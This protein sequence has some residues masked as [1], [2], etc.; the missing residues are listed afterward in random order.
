MSKRRAELPSKI[1]ALALMAI[2]IHIALPASAQT[3]RGG[4]HGTVQD[5][6]NALLPNAEVKATNVETGQVYATLST[7]AGEFTFS[8]L[9]LGSYSVSVRQ[10]GFEP[11]TVSHISVLAGSIYNLPLKVAL[12]TVSSEVNVAASEV[13]L[14]STTSSQSSV[15][16][17]SETENIPLNG[18]DFTQLLTVTPGYSGYGVGFVSAING[19]QASQTNWQIEGVDNNDIWINTSA[20]NQGGVFGI[21]GVLLPLDSV[22]EFSVVTQGTAETGRSPGGTVNLAL[23]SGTND[24]H[25][26][27]YYY[28]RN[29]ALAA[30]PVF[31]DP[32]TGTVVKNKLRDQQ[33]GFTTGGPILKDKTFFFVSYERQAFDIGLPNHVTEPSQAYQT[34]ALAVLNNSG[35][36]YG[37]YAPVPVNPVSVKLLDTLWPASA[38][39]GKAET[40]NYFNPGTE[41][42][43]SNNGV[44]K[45]DHALNENNHLS[46][47]AF[48]A[49]GH[50]TAPTSSYL[51][52]Y[53]ETSPMHVQ[54]WA[55]VYNSTLSPR[56]A[57][58]LLA[59][60]NYFN[61]A[62]SDEN[63]SYNPVALGLNTGVT[64]PQLSGAPNIT[65]GQFDPIGITPYS[66]RHDTTWHLTDAASYS[67][68]KHQLRFG[69]E[70]RRSNV[71]EFYHSG[72][73][74]DFSFTGSQGPWGSST[75]IA[76]PN[77]TA[78]ADFLAGYVSQASIV[79][80]DPA[81]TV[82]TNGFSLFA[83][84]N[85]QVTHQ[86]N[87]NLGLRYDYN[88]PIHDGKSD[89]STFIPGSGGLV[90]VGSGINT[91]YPSNWKNF[92]PHL[93]FAYQPSS[94]A[95]VVLRGGFGL[96]Y[97][98]VAVSSFLGN[99]YIYNGGPAGA[100]DNPAGSKPV[101]TLALYGYTLPTDGSLIGWQTNPIYNLF[102][103][104]QNLRTPY[105]Y[106]FNLNVQK[107][108]G[109]A[110]VAQVGYVG[111][112][113]RHLL[114]LN[115]LNQAAL[116]SEIDPNAYDQNGANT[117]RPY[118]NKFP[119]YGVI[120]QLN[121]SGNSSYNSLQASLRVSGWHGVVSQFSYTWAHTLDYGSFLALPQ[122]SR[123]PAG[124]YGNS[125]FD[126]RQNLT[127]YLLYSLPSSS[128][129][130]R[131]VSD[132]WKLSSLLSFRTGLPFTVSAFSIY[133]DA[134]LTGDFADRPNLTGNP[135]AGVSH[136]VQSH[137]S[138]Q[139][140]NPDAFTI[141]LGQFGTMRRNQLSGPGFSDVD[142]SIL[143]DTPINERVTTQFR[144]EAF[145]LFNRINLGGPTF[146][147][148]NGVIAN[149]GSSNIGIPITYTNGSQFGLPGI[150]PGEPFN[151]Q[152]A[153]KVRF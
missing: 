87:V 44:A 134:S 20:A 64:D 130:L 51:T 60:F 9:P 144:I 31:A 151:L 54:N 22:D 40:G 94:N 96:T 147:G 53:F 110:A 86:L 145:N 112:L 149:P 143:K 26:G 111:S 15:L 118:Y 138:V 90:A 55:V 81:R 115:D 70:Y 98:T 85:F 45:L 2:L 5:P 16:E 41:D 126:Q 82:D 62:F 49:Q 57:N 65:I 139:W 19:A 150:G 133:G 153:L 119:T 67:V 11:L 75:A 109:R 43:Y 152:L 117:T 148:A 1:F 39:T 25:G 74:G 137:Q 4:I 76:D 102:S 56:L 12:G 58:Q 77:V 27:A 100:E 120:D 34:E 35:N 47:R 59:G 141:D 30:D 6:S 124:E 84:D 83:Q 38:L 121:S 79:Q 8:D 132:G 13:S 93:G 29:E 80:G 105:L 99:S 78:L 123:N 48:I 113:G 127:A 32:N 61:Q 52:P 71:D 68:A 14:D 7:S 66:G 42:G 21:P 88:G 136:S 37:T 92:G 63:R 33:Y 125:D 122:N 50:Q 103:V 146:T 106:N 3:F 36:T 140:I 97:D 18:R 28:N 114:L 101:S 108:L 129:R 17:T 116:G 91:L 46:L 73:R 104:S 23:K 142:F 128:G 72:Q 131:Q 95:G 107:S 69:A 135:Y 24:L 10:A 89:L